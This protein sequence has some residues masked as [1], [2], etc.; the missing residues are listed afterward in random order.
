MAGIA[1]LMLGAA[2]LYLNGLRSDVYHREEDVLTEGPRFYGQLPF[3]AQ[4]DLQEKT[5]VGHHR[6]EV[7]APFGPNP[8]THYANAPELFFEDEGYKWLYLQNQYDLRVDPENSDW[9]LDPPFNS[10]LVNASKPISS[11]GLLPTINYASRC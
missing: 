9:R 11:I 10:V 3:V 4:D 2:A 6:T 1:I 8:Q 5:F 7:R